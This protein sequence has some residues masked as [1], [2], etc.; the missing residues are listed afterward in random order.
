[1]VAAHRI[2]LEY[3]FLRHALQKGMSRRFKWAADDLPRVY[4][5]LLSGAEF[6]VSFCGLLDRPP[7]QHRTHHPSL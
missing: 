4:F 6:P 2:E 7:Y 5:D 3:G 1:M